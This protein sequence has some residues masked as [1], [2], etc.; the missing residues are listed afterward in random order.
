MSGASLLYTKNRSLD[1]QHFS[2]PDDR[3]ARLIS[4]TGLEEREDT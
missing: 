1:L 3:N 2:A 4:G